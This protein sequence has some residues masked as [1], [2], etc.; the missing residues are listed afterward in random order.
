MAFHDIEEKNMMDQFLTVKCQLPPG[1]ITRRDQTRSSIPE[2][3]PPSEIV[4]RLPRITR[5]MALAI[6]FDQLIRDRTIL[7]QAELARLGR[8]TR[9]R[10]SQIMNLLHLAPD[11]QEALLFLPRVAPGT[12]SV[13]LA[14]LQL[15]AKT[16]DWTVQRKAWSALIR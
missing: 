12:R 1:T 9:A 4:G 11:I 14:Q 13:I 10:M 5:L 2:T 15:I 7:N 3:A 6:H 8:V 16:L